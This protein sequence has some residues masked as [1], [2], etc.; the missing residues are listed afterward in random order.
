MTK[1][2]TRYDR[3]WQQQVKA[4]RKFI[5]ELEKTPTMHGQKWKDAMLAH[6]R[7][8]LKDMLAQRPKPL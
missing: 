4:L 6:Y 1:A 3:A 5:R 7:G 2:S 8:K